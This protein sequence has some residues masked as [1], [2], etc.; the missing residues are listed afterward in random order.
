MLTFDIIAFGDSF[1]H[2]FSGGRDLLMR[3]AA[4]QENLCVTPEKITLTSDR[5]DALPP[6]LALPSALSPPFGG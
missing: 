6:Q 1:W 3:S 5:Q 4:V 2:I